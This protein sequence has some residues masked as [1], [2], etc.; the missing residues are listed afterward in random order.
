MGLYQTIEVEMKTALKQGD[1]IKLGALRMLIAAVK[2]VQ[3]EKNLKSIE[4]GDVVQVL[5]KQIKQ[6]KES[7]DQFQKGNRPDLVEKEKKEL[8]ILEAYMPKQLSEE[9]V[10]LIVKEAISETG[11]VTRK[12]MGMVMKAVVEKTRGR[13][14]GKII[15]QIVTG[16]LK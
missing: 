9:D 3:I 7:I 10:L 2:M 13:A 14:D 1:S 15:S 5:Q 12:D 8:H 16:L 6:R 4:D 11:A